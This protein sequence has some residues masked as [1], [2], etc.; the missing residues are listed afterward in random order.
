[1]IFK[2][3]FSKVSC[4]T[5]SWPNGLEGFAPSLFFFFVV[6]EF[7]RGLREYKDDLVIFYAHGKLILVG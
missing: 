3:I 1:M 7:S 2:E 6:L 5:F 4:R